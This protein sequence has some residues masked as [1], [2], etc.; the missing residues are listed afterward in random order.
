MKCK[1]IAALIEQLAPVA[2][3]YEWDNVG[4][5]CGDAEQEVTKLLLTLDLDIDVA[6]RRLVKER[7]WWSAITQSSFDPVSRV[8]AQTPDGRLLRT[9]AQHNILITPPTPISTWRGAG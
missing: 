4:L 5:L 8:T 7:R 2:L 3:A 1:E 9:L 6:L